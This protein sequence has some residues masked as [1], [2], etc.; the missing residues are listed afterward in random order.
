MKLLKVLWQVSEWSDCDRK[1]NLT[2]WFYNKITGDKKSL[3]VPFREM[4]GVTPEILLELAPGYDV[5]FTL[6]AMRCGLSEYERGK[7]T[8]TTALP[9]FVV[10]IDMYSDDPRVHKARNLP[11][12]EEEVL[13]ILK[14]TPPPTAIVDTGYGRHVYWALRSPI[15]LDDE[16]AR[17]TAQ[18][19]LSVF[20]EKIC[21]RAMEIGGWHV[22]K[23]PALQHVY[24]VPGTYN[25]K[26]ANN[27]RQVAA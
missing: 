13:E 4:D 10:D 2:F 12:T 26:L 25:Y 3:H 6:A 19:Y 22:D 27:P 21:Q 8:D 5:Y 9:A 7:R 23:T 1:D 15:V 17:R 16:K 24:R 20:Q 14:D 18:G 11:K